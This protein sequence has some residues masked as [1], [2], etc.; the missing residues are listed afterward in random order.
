MGEGENMKTLVHVVLCGLMVGLWPLLLAAQTA[1]GRTTAA[2]EQQPA[3]GAPAQGGAGSADLAK[4]LANPVAALISVPLQNNFESGL[5]ADDKG[6]RYILNF[7]PVIPFTLGPRWNLISR[8]ITPI[9]AQSDIY[10]GAGSQAGIGDIVQSF[11]FSP[12]EGRVV[13]GVGPVF[14]LPTAT[15]RLL[16]GKK[17]G[18]GPTAV[19]LKQQ[20]PWTVGALWNQLWSFAGDDE[21]K[22]VNATFLQPFLS[23]TTRRALGVSIQTES[24]YDWDGEQWTVPIYVGVSQMLRVGRQPLSLS[25]GPRFWAAGPEGA[26]D[27]S[28]RFSVTLLFPK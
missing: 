4:K 1:D 17:W 12:A 11:F 24:T 10:Q 3:A 21:R 7:Q 22:D 13:W 2:G 27:W 19:V 6:F 16:G 20:G 5:G 8:T 23:Y 25:I 14:L 26:P 15:D 28:L 9:V 18:A